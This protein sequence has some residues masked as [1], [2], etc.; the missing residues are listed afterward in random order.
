[1][2]DHAAFLRTLCRTSQL[3]GRVVVLHGS[4]VC[5]I[6]DVP[7][8]TWEMQRSLETHFPH[9]HVDVHACS[10]SLSGFRVRVRFTE[11]EITVYLTTSALLAAMAALTAYCMD[12][13]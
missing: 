13:I 9:A 8:W 2:D 6:L 12:L 3:G 5:E 10:H 7:E 11:R 1:M 4:S